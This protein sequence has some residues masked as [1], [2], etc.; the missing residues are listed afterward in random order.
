MRW[1]KESKDFWQQLTPL[2]ICR[3]D[4]CPAELAYIFYGGIAMGLGSTS[5][6][7][8]KRVEAST[9]SFHIQELNA[10]FPAFET[11]TRQVRRAF[12]KLMLTSVT[13]LCI[14]S[15]SKPRCLTREVVCRKLEESRHCFPRASENTPSRAS[16]KVN[17]PP[18]GND[19]SFSYFNILSNGA[20]LKAF[21]ER[22][23]AAVDQ[24]PSHS[25]ADCVLKLIGKHYRR[26]DAHPTRRWII[27]ERR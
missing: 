15:A 25:H 6:I 14:L 11:R 22:V 10:V 24:L 1:R 2:Q 5:C 23:H 16:P 12:R 21:P 17:R 20:I 4:L 3:S 7:L 18:A 27:S 13:A 8:N 19:V 9:Q 26:L